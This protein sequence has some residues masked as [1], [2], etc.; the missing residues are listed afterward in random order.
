MRIPPKEH[1][2]KPGISG[3]PGGKPKYF[4]TRVRVKDIVDKYLS[5][6]RSQLQ[7]LLIDKENTPAL[8]LMIAATILFCIEEG[9]YSRLESLLQRAVG[10]VKDEIEIET[11]PGEE[12]SRLS[13][14]AL[15]TLV[16]TTL[17]EAI[18]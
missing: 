4:L 8:E 16:Q 5:M 17:P 2:F 10:K 14:N 13:M 1:Q 9:D 18:E 7:K 12:I 15:L 11:N 3:N 6:S